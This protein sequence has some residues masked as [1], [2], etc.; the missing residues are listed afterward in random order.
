[1]I[2]GVP[3]LSTRDREAQQ[4]FAN[5]V[6]VVVDRDVRLVLVSEA[7]VLSADARALDLERTAS[8]LSLLKVHAPA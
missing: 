1:V 8:R 7:D 5:G 4:R 6:D 2:S 3:K